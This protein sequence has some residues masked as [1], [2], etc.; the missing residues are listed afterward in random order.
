MTRPV[1]ERASTALRAEI[2][3]RAA[4]L[5]AEGHVHDFALAKRKA[6][7]QMG[8]TEGRALPSNQE[9]G[10]ALSQYRAVY[11]PEHPELIHDLR[12][13]AAY[14][15]HFFSAYRPYLTGSVL[16]GAAGA[17]SNINLLL[18]HD[19]PKAVEFFLLDQKIDYQHNESAGIQQ[20]TGY[21]TLSF[22][23]DETPV[24]LHVRPLSAE[25]N[26]SHREERATLT[27][28]EH[29]LAPAP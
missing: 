11:N 4:R 25:R 1:I 27:E 5:I 16:S 24:L 9:V 13:K 17:H 28:V 23:Y 15:M 18:Y 14:L 29:L 6:A 12:K 10:D 22:W 2:A 19:D 20:V 21:P 26:A 8:V 7:H 3:A